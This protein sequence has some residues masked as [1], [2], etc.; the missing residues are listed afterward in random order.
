M[1]STTEGQV[2]G[3]E[4]MI[5]LLWV[6]RE[7]PSRGPKPALD[8]AQISEAALRIA[9]AEGFAA[10]SMQRVASEL[11][12][13]KMALYR[14]VTGKAELTAIMIEAAVGEPPDL[15]AVAG[16]WRA[17][18]IVFAELLAATWQ[19]HPWLPL[20][21][22]GDRVMGPK[23]VGWT[24]CAVSALTGTGLDGTEK[25]DAVFLISGHIRNTQSTA[26]AGTQPWSVD[27]HLDPALN[28]LVHDYAD[29]FP[30][31]TAAIASAST[32]AAGAR[33][34]A[35]NG[36]AFGLER[37]LDGLEALVATRTTSA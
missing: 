35:D 26:T 37:I 17:K 22:M 4:A 12:F 31:L 3:R 29:R 14:Y 34:S 1:T 23:E 18:V 2:D 21:T 20:V 24:E 10:V 8:L 13:T 25:M 16:G 27:E 9:D 7:R 33:P 28:G 19:R 32:S 6:G 11:A 15:G 36:R 30:A 5:E